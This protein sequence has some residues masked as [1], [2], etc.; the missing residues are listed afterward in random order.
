MN[1]HKNGKISLAEFKKCK[2]HE[3]MRI[4]DTSQSINDEIS[5][6]SY[7]HFYV[8]Y[9][10]FFD[11]DRD[12][13][14]L[15]DRQEFS[16]YDN[17][18]V[19]PLV[20]DRILQGKCKSLR[21]EHNLDYHDFIW[22]CLSEEDKTTMTSIEFWFRCLDTDGDDVITEFELKQF[23][24]SQKEINSEIVPFD[25]LMEQLSDLIKPKNPP[26]ITL[27]DLKKSKLS[28][29][30]FNAFVNFRKFESFE[31]R[32]TSHKVETTT[33]FW[34]QYAKSEYDRLIQESVDDEATTP[35]DSFNP[36]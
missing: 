17:G 24:D 19:T 14:S 31:G 5:Y 15:V 1:T 8:L 11:L 28:F 10:K 36:L 7:E 30:F 27:Q 16:Y 3:T 13:D 18:C 23:Y 22:F 33:N 35:V 29:L 21:V 25:F 2:F 32:E 34:A 9:C 12:T 26:L 4:L 20:L 6:F